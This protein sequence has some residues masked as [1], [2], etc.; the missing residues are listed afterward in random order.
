MIWFAIGAAVGLGSLHYSLV[1]RPIQARSPVDAIG[2]YVI[3]G[4][5]G[6]IV[7]GTPLWL[8]FGWW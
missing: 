6:A 8:M 2:G 5:A 7:I 1:K 3:S 4:A